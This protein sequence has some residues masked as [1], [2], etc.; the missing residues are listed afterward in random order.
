[1]VGSTDELRGTLRE[2]GPGGPDPHS[3]RNGGIEH[4]LQEFAELCIVDHDAVGIHLEDQFGRTVALGIEDRL[5]QEVHEH[6]I[7]QTTG[8]DDCHEPGRLIDGIGRTR[9]SGLR[10]GD[11]AGEH[12]AERG[13]D[14]RHGSEDLPGHG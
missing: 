10:T 9:V 3:N 1:M 8:L 11:G 4:L 7:E 5:M 12:H 2:A 6:R 14:Q 13:D